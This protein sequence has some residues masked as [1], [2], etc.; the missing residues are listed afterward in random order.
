M[1]FLNLGLFLRP[2]YKRTFTVKFLNVD[3]DFVVID[4]LGYAS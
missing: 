3:A 2:K 1:H 4:H